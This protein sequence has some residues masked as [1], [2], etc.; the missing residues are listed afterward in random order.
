MPN[1]SS[2]AR[3]LLDPT[4]KTTPWHWGER[5]FKAFEELKMRMCSSPVLTQPNFDKQ[6]ILQV[7]ASAYGVGAI[8]SQEGDPTT[9]TPSLKQQTK[10]ALHPV[11]YYSATFTATKQNYNI[12]ERELLAIMKALAHWRLYL[13]WT[14]VPF[15]IWTD[16]ANLQ[17]WK[18]PRNLN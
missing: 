2:I 7:D 4:K 11:A 16:H 9:L 14:K 6:F 5:Q 13:G 1:Y 17:Y 8:L 15:I 3:P 12:Y 18:L 10:P